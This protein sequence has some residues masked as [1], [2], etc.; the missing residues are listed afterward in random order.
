MRLLTA[1]SACVILML[2]LALSYGRTDH[3][4]ELMD[5]LFFEY[6]TD[7]Q[8]IALQPWEDEEEERYYL[9]LPSCFWEKGG[10]FVL[11][12]AGGRY[13]FR[14]NGT[15]CKDGEVIS[16]RDGQKLRMEAGGIF[17]VRYMDKTLQVIASKDLPAV[18]FWAQ[19][20]ESVLDVEEFAGKEYLESGRMVMLDASG[21]VL[22]A[23]NL[24][25]FRVRGNLTATL[26]KKPFTFSFDRPIGLLGMAP[27]GKWNLLANATDGSYMRNKIVLDL[28]NESMG[29]YQPDGEFAEVYLNGVY[30]GLYLLTEA[31]EIGENR[32]ND[33]ASPGWYL[34]MELDFRMKEETPYVITDRGQIFA[35]ESDSYVPQEQKEQIQYLVND[36]ESALFAKD[37]ASLLSGKSLDQLIDLE[38]WAQAFLVQEISGDHDTGI[39]SQF[40]YIP[41][42]ESRL[43]AGPI[44]DF[45]GTMGNVNTPMFQNP[46]ALTASI[47]QSRPSGNANQNR[48]FAAMYRN[49]QFRKVVE[50]KYREVFRENLGRMICEGIGSYA[51]GIERSAMLDA[52]RWHEERFTWMFTIPQNARIREEGDWTR[53]DTLDAHVAFVRDFLASK[54]EFLDSLWVEKED[55]CVVEVRNE[56]PFLN[57]DYNQ[58][59]YYWVPRGES[60]EGL[61]G[62]EQEG[63]RFLGYRD[64]DTGQMVSDGAVIG[65]DCILEA[66]WEIKR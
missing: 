49:P 61:F 43:Y 59:L 64:R 63:Y 57:Q 32:M 11:R 19:S 6:A 38:S 30:Q 24:P 62:Y 27:A 8:S 48:W 29:G 21:K 44:W 52:L 9:F 3:E 16:L 34:E 12:C 14:I 53:F 23:E 36:I 40:A 66:E 22:C 20:P 18:L 60:I 2:A 50:E 39:A 42:G 13:D 1:A 31:V 51:A 25:K 7:G 47:E 37:G 5:T 10:E 45:D 26:G 58:T 4:K 17:G 35:V 56:A 55:Y 65:K 54:K 28:A 33:L 15:S 46:R 41:E